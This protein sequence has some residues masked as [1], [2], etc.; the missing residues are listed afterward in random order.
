MA[1]SRLFKPFLWLGHVLRGLRLLVLNLITL[2]VLVLLIATMVIATKP[3]PA[4]PANAVLRLDLRGGL[5]NVRSKPSFTARILSDLTEP[6]KDGIVTRRLVTAIHRAAVDSRIH[7]LDLNLSN[8]S[9]GTVTQLDQVARALQYF[10]AHGKPIYAFSPSYTQASYA[11]A[12]QASRIY[13]PRLGFVL[14]SGFTTKGLYF[15]GLLDKVGVNVYAFR[16]GKY[17]SA[18]EPLTRGNMSQPARVENRAWLRVWWQHYRDLIAEGRDLHD[19]QVSRYVEHLPHLLQAAQGNAA[20]LALRQ[21]LITRIDGHHAMEEAIARVVHTK[22]GDVPSLSWRSYLTATR[23]SS[24]A[25]AKAQIAVVPIDGMLLPG[26]TET[27]G[28]VATGPTVAQLRQLLHDSAVKAVVLQMDSPGG[29]VNTANAVRRAIEKL[30]H[31]GKPVVVSMGTLGASGAYWLSTAANAIYAEPTTLTADIGVFVLIPNFSELLHKIGA[32]YS[33]ISVPSSGTY[34]SSYAPLSQSDRKA[35]QALVDHIYGHF[36]GLVAKAR[37]L[38]IAKVYHMAQGRAWSG[39]AAYHL[40]LINGLG[41]LQKGIQKA[42]QLAHLAVGQYQ[43][44]YLSRP[45]TNWPSHW[46]RQAALAMLPQ[47]M[48][49]TSSLWENPSILSQLRLIA[50]AARP[51][52]VF[53][54][55]PDDPVVH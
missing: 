11:L 13:L 43:V 24:P 49:S 3:A 5:R 14:I 12:A 39:E 22:V 36:V 7:L 44:H 30:R 51:Y 10:R 42:A 27:R 15:K 33:G 23:Q 17:K 8:F 25:S 41:G 48:V 2:A 19:E 29:D 47:G 20:E 31:A 46:V 45:S 4:V 34:L 53:S 37:H 1:G 55:L 26:N 16:Q 9:G 28:V 50:A 35:F 38:P 52:G 40:G 6:A 21:G 54:Y 32:G 18:V